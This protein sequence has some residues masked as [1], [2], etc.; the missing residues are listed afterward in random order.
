MKTQT[1]NIKS[2]LRSLALAGLTL[3]PQTQAKA[4]LAEKLDEVK[5]SGNVA[6]FA[7]ADSNAGAQTT[8]Q[9]LNHSLA[10]PYTTKVSGFVDLYE[11]NAGY[12]GK[13]I[14]EK[15]LVDK[16]NFRTHLESI[17]EPLTRAGFG[18]SYALPTPKGT[19][20]KVCYLPLYV[21]KEGEKIDN[22]Q[23][24]GFAFGAD[25]PYDFS[26][27]AFGEMNIATKKGVQWNYGEIELARKFGE[28]K[29]FSIGLNL[30]LNNNGAGNPLPEVVPRI[31]LRA[32]F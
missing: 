18:L 9:E 17:N 3:L 7:G 10:L 27:I 19:F 15:G 25:L 29:R 14:V 32:K 2:T 22:R 4:D 24:V 8:Y 11:N 28:E 26:L 20:A 16:L 6:Y 21:D 23:V 13:T 12:F 31:A 5:L 30:Q 1:K